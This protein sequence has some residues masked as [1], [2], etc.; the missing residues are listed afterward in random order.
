MISGDNEIDTECENSEE[1]G[2]RVGKTPFEILRSKMT[3]ILPNDEEGVV[4]RVL[5][6]GAGLIIPVGS[7][8]R[9][10]KGLIRFL[11]LK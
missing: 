5:S 8:V 11:I 2:K 7:R 3:S 1:D 6:S 4:K 10:K 9:S